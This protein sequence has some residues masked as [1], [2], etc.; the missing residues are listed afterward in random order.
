MQRTWMLIHMELGDR[1]LDF[2]A[3]QDAFSVRLNPIVHV[4][5]RK[6][7]GVVADLLDDSPPRRRGA[8]S[9]LRAPPVYVE[10]KS[11]PFLYQSGENGG[12][13]EEGG[14]DDF[15][16]HECGFGEYDF[17][18]PGTRWESD[19]EDERGDNEIFSPIATKAGQDLGSI[20]FAGASGAPSCELKAAYRLQLSVRLDEKR[21]ALIY[22]CFEYK[23][24]ATAPS[25]P[26]P[27]N[28]SMRRFQ[29]AMHLGE[30]RRG[31]RFGDSS[32]GESEDEEDPALDEPCEPVRPP[33]G[34]AGRVAFHLQGHAGD[35][36]SSRVLRLRV[37]LAS[38]CGAQRAI[39]GGSGSGRSTIA[40]P[41]RCE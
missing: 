28:R 16:E 1:K 4:M 37:P 33:E 38:V 34:E 30:P 15:A 18:H 6:R 5:T 12:E 35:F 7:L 29:R 36:L 23:G 21:E 13:D 3:L 11:S 17:R 10:P 26:L 22:D 25:D 27:T 40:P 41:P 8:P 32:E 31:S 19:D 2:Y 14:G 24:A 39:A 20:L 9:S